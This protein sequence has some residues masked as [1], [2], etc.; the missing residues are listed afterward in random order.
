LEVIVSKRPA[1]LRIVPRQPD[2][3]PDSFFAEKRYWLKDDPVM[4]HFMNAL[5]STFP[6]GERFFID[7][8]R[9][10]R[11]QVG[12]ENLPEQL[13]QDIRDFIRQEAWHGK[14]HEQW[15]QALVQLGYTEMPAFSARLKKL[16]LWANDNISAMNRL[17]MTAAA[18]HLTASLARL[19]LEKRPDLLEDA[20]RPVRDLLAWHALEE[21]EHKS[22]C[23]DLYQQA[24]GGYWRR[25]L[26][27]GVELI[28]LFV[29][30][31]QRHRY[32]LRQD[33]LWNWRSRW[34]LFRDI[35]GP[36]GVIGQIMPFLLRYLKPG[37]HPW[38][39]DE[40]QGFISRFG[41]LLRDIDK[42]LA[43]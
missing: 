39:T 27:L 24:G 8:A 12:E 3:R 7:S 6:E 25:C 4:T 34:R 40:R 16:R 23:F 29:Q 9:A 20:S 15:D 37:F 38:D 10:V 18:E 21:T 43:A 42:N 13:R 1:D 11:E 28:D 41:Y 30:V 22:V 17:A 26:M 19:L 14:E 33:G 31:H 35:W 2:F 32:L 36:T 5:Q